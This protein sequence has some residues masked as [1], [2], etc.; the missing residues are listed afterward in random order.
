MANK[1]VRQAAREAKEAG[2]QVMEQARE[3]LQAGAQVATNVAHTVADAAG[4][5]IEAVTGTTADEVTTA[6][7]KP[8]RGSG[9]KFV[10]KTAALA[11]AEQAISPPPTVEQSVRTNDA[12]PQGEAPEVQPTDEG[13][14][15]SFPDAT[16]DVVNPEPA[17]AAA[18]APSAP[19]AEAPATQAEEE[20]KAL[21]TAD[22]APSATGTTQ[23]ELPEW[24][25][26]LE[27]SKS[28][29]DT[30]R[31]AA[32][33]DRWGNG[34]DNPPASISEM[35]GRLMAEGIKEKAVYKV[36]RVQGLSPEAKAW[37]ER[38]E[39]GFNRF[40][41]LWYPGAQLPPELLE[42]QEGAQAGAAPA[43]PAEGMIVSSHLIFHMED[44]EITWPRAGW[45]K[46]AKLEFGYTLPE[47]AYRWLNS[48]TMRECG[49]GPLPGDSSQT[50]D[51]WTGETIP[52]RW[53]T[54]QGMTTYRAVQTAV[55]PA[56]SKAAPP[57]QVAQ[58]PAVA[59]TP[60][61]VASPAPQPELVRADEVE[62]L[63][64]QN[65]K[66]EEKVRRL[67]L[68]AE[69]LRG[70]AEMAQFAIRETLQQMRQEVRNESAP[71]PQVSAAPISIAELKERRR[72]AHEESQKL[73]EGGTSG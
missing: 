53:V 23:D 62:P 41:P 26:N 31:A 9:G 54:E 5:A 15:A 27:E 46:P 18:Q 60:P 43:I 17:D 66:L 40:S 56:P 63:I 13:S 21:P 55:R 19:E 67:E 73:L 42:E 48:Q 11:V 10:S 33:I 29:T 32:L 1:R 8:A 44:I 34:E 52:G 37:A 24:K 36:W 39:F 6:P 50:Y 22:D 45:P 47:P 58:P 68:E 57:Q 16:I 30:K 49:L 64:L 28:N 25:Q 4:M 71:A 7:A 72:K 3:V 59:P 70:K 35:F 69:F 14:E 61:Q 65:E 20:S 12:A 2:G 51:P 38:E